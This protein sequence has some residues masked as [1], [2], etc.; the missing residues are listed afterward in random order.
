MDGR[1]SIPHSAFRIPHWSSR[2]QH[3]QR[4]PESPP[5]RERARETDHPQAARQ[6]VHDPRDTWGRQCPERQAGERRCAPRAGQEGPGRP[7][8]VTV[9]DARWTHR[10][11]A[12]AAQAAVDTSAR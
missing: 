7:E 6:G 8:P 9:A 12:A 4:K 11:A 3:P 5:T 1:A 10:L 2:R